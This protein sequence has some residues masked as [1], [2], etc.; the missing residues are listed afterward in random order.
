MSSLCP[1]SSP[2]KRSPA[3]RSRSGYANQSLRIGTG[4]L[5][6]RRNVCGRGLTWVIKLRSQTSATLLV[7][8]PRRLPVCC[9]PRTWDGTD[10][11]ERSHR[12][13]PEGA[14]AGAASRQSGI[15]ELPRQPGEGAA[16]AFR[17]REWTVTLFMMAKLPAM[18]GRWLGGALQAFEDGGGHCLE[19]APSAGS[20]G[21]GA[22][23][24]NERATPDGSLGH[25]WRPGSA[26]FVP[27]V[28]TG[29]RPDCSSAPVRA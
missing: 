25:R 2:R 12:G 17:R 6:R 22:G 8:Y 27:V 11:V 28:G 21:L 16:G 5:D 3:V 10:C 24:R 20:A 29:A 7:T 9:L 14:I 4:R 13:D 19:T 26:Q 1:R 15:R 23:S 18:R